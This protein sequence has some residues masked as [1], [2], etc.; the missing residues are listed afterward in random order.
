M[1]N[2]TFDNVSDALVVYALALPIAGTIRM[3]TAKP[4]KAKRHGH[5]LAPAGE[6]PSMSFG[7]PFPDRL[8]ELNSR[9]QL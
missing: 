3:L 8:Q 2:G 5:K 7:F 1:L 9:K 6:S 4:P